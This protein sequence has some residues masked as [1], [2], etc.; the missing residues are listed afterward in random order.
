MDDAVGRLDVQLEHTRIV[1]GDLIGITINFN[2]QT[3]AF[4]RSRASIPEFIGC[5]FTA[6]QMLHQ[7]P[8]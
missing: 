3:S 1:H 7:N 8:G 2:V 5:V 4:N 6:K